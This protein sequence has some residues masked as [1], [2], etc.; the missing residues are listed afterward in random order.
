MGISEGKH[1]RQQEQQ[2]QRPEDWLLF[3]SLRNSSRKKGVGEIM[4]WG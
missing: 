2:V 4:G 1:S 3:A